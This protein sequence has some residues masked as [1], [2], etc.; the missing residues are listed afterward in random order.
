MVLPQVIDG[1]SELVPLQKLWYR[2]APVELQIPQLSDE[3]WTSVG[4]V[5]SAAKTMPPIFGP[6]QLPC[7][8]H[9]RTLLDFDSTKGHAVVAL[10]MKALQLEREL[11][12]R[13]LRVGS[14]LGRGRL[15]GGRERTRVRVGGRA[16]EG[17]VG[18]VT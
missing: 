12:I 17:S 3:S 18:F 16:G 2:S 6:H 8:C 13:E 9:T 7:R 10:G 15:K 5:R 1:L 11:A 14:T 4:A